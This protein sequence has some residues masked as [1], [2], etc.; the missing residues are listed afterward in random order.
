MKTIIR[1]PYSNAFPRSIYPR[2]ALWFAVLMPFL[3]GACGE[4]ESERVSERVL[5]LTA[6]D[7]DQMQAA[8]E[9]ELIERCSDPGGPE[10]TVEAPLQVLIAVQRRDLCAVMDGDARV[11][12]KP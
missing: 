8:G 10:I 7:F 6:E 3:L 2:Q 12:F 4:S 9:D 11:I 1:L 5:V